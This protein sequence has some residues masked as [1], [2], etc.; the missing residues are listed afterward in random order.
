[1]AANGI[2]LNR[3]L[4]LF[5]GVPY[6]RAIEG[7]QRLPRQSA[8]LLE[9]ILEYVRGNLPEYRIQVRRTLVHESGLCLELDED[10]VDVREL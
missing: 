5:T 9:N 7:P 4:G 8:L 3:T 6:A 10:E 2:D 1:M